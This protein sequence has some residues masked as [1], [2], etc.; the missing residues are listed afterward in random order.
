LSIRELRMSS[1]SSPGGDRLG[2]EHALR[3]SLPPPA[4]GSAR[5]C[6]GR[7]CTVDLHPRTWWSGTGRSRRTRPARSSRHGVRGE[8]AGQ[9]LIHADP[10]RRCR[11]C[12]SGWRRRSVSRAVSAVAQTVVTSMKRDAGGPQERD[13]PHRGFPPR[14]SADG[15]LDR[16]HSTPASCSAD[17]NGSAP[18]SMADLV[19]EAGRNGW[20]PTPM[21]ATVG[22]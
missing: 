11:I 18:M 9:V 3:D 22:M 20:T 5:I 15:V 6:R 12:R 7:A 17:R 21:I 2:I 10:R 16:R 13:K 4:P 14:S 8:G 1:S 19:S